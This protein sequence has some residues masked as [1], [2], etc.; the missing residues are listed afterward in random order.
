MSGHDEASPSWC[1]VAGGFMHSPANMGYLS[2]V[3]PTGAGPGWTAGLTW[4]VVPAA[5]GNVAGAFFLVAL[6]FWLVRR[7]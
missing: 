7:P 6:P 2:L 4:A 1:F 3:Q 5:I